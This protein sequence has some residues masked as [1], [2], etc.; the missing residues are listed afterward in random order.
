MRNIVIKLLKPIFISL[1]VYSS[2]GFVLLPY[3]AQSNFSKIIKQKTSADATLGKVYFNPFT[4]ELI[5]K[6]LLIHDN[7]NKTLI[8]FKNFYINFGI[9]TILKDTIIVQDIYLENLKGNIEIDSDK[10][11]NFQYILSYIIKQNNSKSEKRKDT[12]VNFPAIKFNNIRFKSNIISFIDN[13]KSTP[14]KVI[15]KRFD[16]NLHDISTKLNSKGIFYTNIDTKNTL[17]LAI[18]STIS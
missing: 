15:T 7:K 8:Y 3:L 4:F 13:S 14:F 10:K 16:I 12:K 18:K 1:I 6:D 5:L 9:T 2:L 11:T 17:K